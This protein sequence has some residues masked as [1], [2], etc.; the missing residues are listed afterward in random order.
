M[1]DYLSLPTL[2][3]VVPWAFE[4]HTLLHPCFFPGTIMEQRG[5]REIIIGQLGQMPM[6]TNAH[7]LL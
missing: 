2:A 6:L 1:D 5:H 3:D 4:N 7:S